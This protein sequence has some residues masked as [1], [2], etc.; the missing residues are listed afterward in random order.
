VNFNVPVSTFETSQTATAINIS[1]WSQL[2]LTCTGRASRTLAT[3]QRE[4][5]ISDYIRQ[6]AKIESK[7]IDVNFFEPLGRLSFNRKS[8]KISVFELM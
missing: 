2:K 3:A 6:L 4:M 8:K 5:I 1:S 7:L